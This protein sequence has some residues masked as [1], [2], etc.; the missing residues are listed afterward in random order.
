MQTE[1]EPLTQAWLCLRLTHLSL[2]SLSFEFNSGSPIAITYQQQVWQCNAKALTSGISEGM[3]ISHALILNPELQLHERNAQLEAKKLQNLSYW[4]YRYT[5]LVSLHN[6]NLL[7]LEI[8]RSSKLFNS[9]NKLINLIK[10]DLSTFKI[11]AKL[12]LAQTPKAS[13]VLSQ[14]NHQKLNNSYI[15][16]AKAKIEHLEQDYKTSQKLHH[17]GFQTLNDIKAIPQSELG[18]RF[19]PNL[20]VYLRQ[21]WGDLADP[22][23]GITPPE[24]FHAR[25]DFSEPIRN[26]TWI[27]QQFDRLLD[28]LVHFAQSRQLICRGFRWHFYH[29]N[30]HLIKTVY[31]GA[32]TGKN[33]SSA[34]KELT[35]LT[36]ENTKFDWELSSIALS[37]THLLPIKLFNDDLFTPPSKQ[38]QLQQL[39]DKLVSRLGHS[40]IFDISEKNEHLP[41]FANEYS[42][43]NREQIQETPNHYQTRLIDSKAT[44]KDEPLWLL[45]KP[46]RLMQH[47][48]EPLLEG[49]LN[50]IHGP[51][52]ISSHWWQAQQSRDYFIARQR[53]GR[54]LWIFFDRVN[55]NWFLHGLYA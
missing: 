12:G 8:G 39:V 43:I 53:S 32:S 41:E 34:F 30:N 5:S 19:G 22:Q 4:A 35:N 29:E 6:E 1:K 17:C 38:E 33:S 47:N 27:Q 14:L 16:L 25:A 20:L 13:I 2:N 40:A 31:I 9:L 3:N 44:F 42:P 51:N 52:R 48:L 36:L 24:T 26:I 28:D 7:L 49:R 18:S 54:L 46:R 55:R 45:E 37:S 15:A 21:L 10:Q 11:D 50:I 23:T